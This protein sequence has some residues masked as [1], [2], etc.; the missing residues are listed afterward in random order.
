MIDYF[1]QYPHQIWEWLILILVLIF[2]TYALI[3]IKN[4]KNTY[5]KNAIDHPFKHFILS[6]PN[7]WAIKNP[8]ENSFMVERADTTYDWF[9]L[10]K[11]T[12][13]ELEPDQQIENILTEE[14][15][16][17]DGDTKIVHS[18]ISLME[19]FIHLELNNE[20]PRFKFS[21]L[22]GTGTEKEEHRIYLDLL[23]IY[24]VEQKGTL[25]C[26]SRSS[27]LNGCVEGPYFEEVISRIK[28][29]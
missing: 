13:N 28:L 9:A 12:N 27:I 10:F 16:V 3:S 5:L 22:E 11:W 24:D 29:V 7:W 25:I 14:K 2:S 23:V 17:V 18:P 4:E 20:K 19:N 8:T 26:Y 15:I 1:R 21:R 6:L